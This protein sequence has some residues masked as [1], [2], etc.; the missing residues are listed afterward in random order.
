MEAIE[1]AAVS[2]WQTGWRRAPPAMAA[3]RG[4]ALAADDDGKGRRTRPKEI[5][6]VG[7]NASAACFGEISSPIFTMR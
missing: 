2:A 7:R 4:E 1:I 3:R 6:D 5:G